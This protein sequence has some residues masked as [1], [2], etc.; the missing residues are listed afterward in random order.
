MK[1]ILSAGAVLVTI[2]LAIASATSL[3]RQSKK[4]IV[5]VTADHVTWFT[6]PYS[7]RIGD[8]ERSCSAT[9]TRAVRGL[10]A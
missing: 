10:T 3:G 1:R 2:V 6:P 5:A 8:S 9:R 4:G 7:T